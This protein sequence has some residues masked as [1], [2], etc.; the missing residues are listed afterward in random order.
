MILGLYVSHLSVY[1]QSNKSDNFILSLDSGKV[2]QE[3]HVGGNKPIREGI[4]FSSFPIGSV[5][6]ADGNTPYLCN[7]KYSSTAV[8]VIIV[9]PGGF[10]DFVK[11][12]VVE[13][14]VVAD[15]TG[16]VKGDF[17]VTSSD[18]GCL[19]KAAETGA[20]FGVALSGLP[21]NSK[22]LIKVRL[23]HGYY[24]PPVKK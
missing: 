15:E 16:I 24:V 11:E 20:Y 13:V 5:I 10:R 1:G 12:G 17:L 2:I 9:I 7:K 23:E 4:D 18:A 21:A 19:M 3:K 6:E 22:G 14:L 8:G